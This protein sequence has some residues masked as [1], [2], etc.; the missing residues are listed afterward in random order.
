M[1]LVL[2]NGYPFPY[3]DNLSEAAQEE[4][5]AQAGGTQ[6]VLDGVVSLQFL[7]TLTVEFED[8][9][10]FHKAK[11]LTGWRRWCENVL[12]AQLGET[13]YLLPGI[14]VENTSFAGFFLYAPEA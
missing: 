6:L 13:E 10:A 5:A 7:H 8:S 3:P 4:I 11:A 14:V 1:Q 12:E 9:V 2:Q